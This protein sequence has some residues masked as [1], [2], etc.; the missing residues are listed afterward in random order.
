MARPAARHGDVPLSAARHLLDRPVPPA[1]ARHAYGPAPSQYGELWLPLGPGP[2]PL[3][4]AIHGGYWKAIYDLG[5]MGHL[6]AALAADGY[7]CWN[8]EYRRVGEAGGGWPG[9]FLDVAA[10]ADHA[11][12]LATTA[13]LDLNRVVT[14]GHSAGGHLALWLAAR[15][16]LPAASPLCTPDPL[17]LR[18][19]V[20][21]AG[22]VDL[23]LADRWRLSDDG[24]ATRRLMGGSPAQHPA[25]YAA[26][27]PAALLPLGLP[28]ILIHGRADRMVPVR[29]SRRYAAAAFRAG[30]PVQ[31][32]DLPDTDHF[33]I[34]DP[35]SA[36]WDIVLA[37]LREVVTA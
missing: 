26:G 16:R 31:F 18:A 24:E 37:A 29:I 28:Q 1:P 6:C 17:P 3:I 19:A 11:R 33:A 22:V 10:A 20:A 21:L 36:Q 12:S 9:T 8:I 27:S 5:Y 7:A 2:H 4:I 14:L 13:P 23:H 15:A 30:D 34:V 35:A 25:R 32:F